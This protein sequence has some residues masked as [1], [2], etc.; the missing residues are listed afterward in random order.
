MIADLTL[1]MHAQ[2]IAPSRLTRMRF[3]LLELLARRDE[4]HTALIAYSGDAHLVSPLTDD[5]KTIAALVPSL[6]PEIMPSI[7]SNATAAFLLAETLLKTTP[8]RARVVWFTDEV[9]SRDK[10]DVSRLVSASG[11]E[12]SHHRHR[13]GNR[14]P[15]TPAQRKI[16]QKCAR[17]NRNGKT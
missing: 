15:D 13:H 8:D 10:A 9:L 1:S 16:P 4:G 14:W 12:L 2:D 5:A 11:A 17:H 7:G 3:K 6:S